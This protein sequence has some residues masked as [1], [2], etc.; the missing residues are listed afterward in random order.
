M[1]RRNFLKNSSLALISAG[2]LKSA[3][4]TNGVGADVLKKSKKA[5]NII[6]L[7]SDG[8][9]TGTMAMANLL[10]QRKEGRLSNWMQLYNDN[11]VSRALMDT[12]SA[13][14]MVTDS[15]A[16][17]SSWGGGVRVKNGSLN[18]NADGSTNTPILQK[19]K[20]AGKSVGCVTSVPVAH[21][22]PAGFCVT[23]KSRGSMED[24]ASDY[25]QLRFDVMM[26]GA[27]ELFLAS[28]RKDK[29]D[30]FKEFTDG[31]FSVVKSRNEMLQLPNSHSRPVLG[32]FNTKS[33]PYALDRQNDAALKANTPTL[34]E[35]SKTAI[36]HLSQNKKGFVLQIEGGKVDWAA[37]SNDAGALLYDQ[38]AFDDAIK[39]AIDFA[40]ADKET[41]VIITT[42]HGNANPGLF[43]GSKADKNF[44]RL[45]NFKHTND[46]VLMG[47]NRNFS[48]QQ[49]IER[50]EAAQGYAITT[51]E[52]KEILTHYEKLDES[53]L[54]NSYKL[55][56]KVLA[57]IQQNY[58]SI[59]WGSM[60]HSGD[61]VELAMYGPGSEKL[62]P[63][64]KNYEL[65]NFMLQAAGVK[66]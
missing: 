11:L 31:G 60:D 12:A 1:E 3:S 6:F 30:L 2:L 50:L 27:T 10:L 35:M 41:L 4:A 29:R 44:E 61:H 48:T 22:T 8:M 38:I 39:V 13:S 17:S 55:P 7:V 49:V 18:T 26:G 65:H 43:Y 16:A 47:I 36:E 62:K 37:H 20:A 34:A 52:A 9:S 53:G 15:A 51:D 54:Y 46:W 66:V 28:E 24:I 57:N 59:G 21:A 45:M 40:K 64:V 56:F 23:Q 63:F 33:L 58:T 42:D 5:K 25:L 19:F 32:V 14:S